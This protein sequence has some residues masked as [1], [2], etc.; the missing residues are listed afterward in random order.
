MTCLGTNLQKSACF[1]TSAL[2]AS[3]PARRKP[4]GDVQKNIDE[5][6][7]LGHMDNERREDLAFCLY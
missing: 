7:N 4:S 6:G 2:L 5:K 3:V 1:L